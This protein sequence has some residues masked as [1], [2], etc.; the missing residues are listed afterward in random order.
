MPDACIEEDPLLG[1]DRGDAH[2]SLKLPR[3]NRESEGY[4][5]IWQAL[6]QAWQMSSRRGFIK[7]GAGLPSNQAG[8]E[9]A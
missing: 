8:V 5:R 6:G 1:R 3:T 9:D 7:N 4:Y 2:R